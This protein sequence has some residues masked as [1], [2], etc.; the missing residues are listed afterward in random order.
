MTALVLA[1]LLMAIPFLFAAVST[2]LWMALKRP[3]TT[4]GHPRSHHALATGAAADIAGHSVRSASAI[5]EV[6]PMPSES[7][8]Y[9]DLAEALAHPWAGA[10]DDTDLDYYDTPS[11]NIWREDAQPGR[12]AA[13]V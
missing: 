8:R 10:E 9:D 7:S 13:K 3:G 12:A 2:W 11:G 4:P 6:Q 5:A 1:G